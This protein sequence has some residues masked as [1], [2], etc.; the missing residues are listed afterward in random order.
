[1]SNNGW[2]NCLKVTH[3]YDRILFGLK[4]EANSV[5]QINLENVMIS[6]MIQVQKDK[7]VYGI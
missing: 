2:I 5:I 3:T 1:M 4:M 7:L 6:E